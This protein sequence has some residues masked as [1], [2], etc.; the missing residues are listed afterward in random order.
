MNLSQFQNKLWLIG[1]IA[2]TC[3]LWLMAVANAQSNLEPIP[4]SPP[5]VTQQLADPVV[6]VSKTKLT[7]QLSSPVVPAPIK[8]GAPPLS[9]GLILDGQSVLEGI[10]VRGYEDG[11]K[12]INF[13]RWLVPFDE[14]IKRLGIKIKDVGK[15]DTIELS[16]ASFRVNFD[17]RKL[18]DDP[19]LGRSIS[20]TNLQSIG[21]IKAKF[22]LYK[23][24]IAVT[25]PKR[26]STD[27][28]I[29]SDIPIDLDGLQTITSGK[30]GINAIQQQSNVSG[31]SSDTTRTSGELRAIGNIGTG[32]WQ[33]RI[34]QPTLD[35][36]SS[37]NLNSATVLFQGHSTDWAIGAQQPFWGQSFNQTGSYWGVT[38]ISRSGFVTPVSTTSDFSVSDRL[39]SSRVWRSIIGQATPG[40]VVQLVRNLN[41]EVI[42]EVLVDSS[43][44]YRFENIV[45][46]SVGEETL[47]QD[48]RLLLY[49]RGQLTASPETR[50]VQF[51]TLLGQLP[52]GASAWVASAGGN[53]VTSGQFGNFDAAQG[54]VLYRRGLN[55]SLTVG[56]GSVYAGEVR[57]VGEVLFQ[58]TGVPLELAGSIVTGTNS[59]LLGRLSYQPST[60]FSLSANI[61]KLSTRSD[62]SWRL[63]P[64]FAATASYDSQSTTKIG[65]EFTARDRR[66]TSSI[67][68]SIDARDRLSVTAR[69]AFDKLQFG[70]QKN[71]VSSLAE[72]SYRMP[73]NREEKGEHQITAAYQTNS[74]GTTTTFGSLSW[75]YRSPARNSVGSYLWQSEIG[76]GQGLFGS[77]VIAGIDYSVA[78]G[79]QVKGRYRGATE[80]SSGNDFS[81]ELTTTIQTQGEIKGTDKSIQDLAAFG[82][83]KIVPFF[84]RN[85]NNRQ[86]SGEEGYFDPLL[87]EINRKSLRNYSAQTDNTISTLQLSPGSYRL[88]LNPAGYPIS[89]RSKSAALKIDIVAGTMTEIPIPLIPA[90]AI[91]G[92]AKNS[93]GEPII[94]G[95]V[96]AVSIANGENIPQ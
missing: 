95:R 92:T 38:T 10:N 77:G 7:Q 51:T 18:I 93:T 27:A 5:K 34:D 70:Y 26:S 90:Y 85:G 72:I 54:G 14:V 64:G 60:Q 2:V 91:T 52:S 81:V 35:G 4:N 89:Y 84:D 1:L 66:N 71:D 25:M 33:V 45:V 28:S 56:V 63:S 79:W 73:I 31:S 30:I 8:V 61:D 41:T 12:A 50:D 86:D 78:P 82:Q 23:Y 69:Q 39:L 19:A 65:G 16:S 49:P 21:G 83:V 67:K 53:R 6:P 37:W 9:V 59:V 96:E 47:G 15:G 76:Y 11:E 36:L 13:E 48:Y 58:P 80:S 32:S 62:L 42:K 68:A 75:K 46:G 55:E 44:T 88:D 43:G 74:S 57:G 29:A 94:G 40:T 20:I 3:W 22:D 87:V 24:A 17:T